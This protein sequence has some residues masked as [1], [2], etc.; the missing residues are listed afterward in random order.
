MNAQLQPDID[1]HFSPWNVFPESN[2]SR[3]TTYCG[4]ARRPGGAYAPITDNLDHVGCDE[5]LAHLE[6]DHYV[7]SIEWDWV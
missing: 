5:C 1:Y 2:R 4:V 7:E 6:A 3:I